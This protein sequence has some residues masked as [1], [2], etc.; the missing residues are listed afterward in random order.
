MQRRVA[1]T[2]LASVLM[3]TA[4]DRSIGQSIGRVGTTAAPFLK[5]GVGSRAMSMGEAYTTQAEDV[6]AMFW[7]PAGIASIAG[8]Q[9]LFS[10]YS[11]IADVAYSY[12]GV[13]IP[14]GGIGTFGAFVGYMD[15][16]TIE[17]T[18]IQSP[19][20]TGEQVSANS[21]V[22]GL[23][24]GR[25]LTDR[26]SLGGNVKYVRETIWHSTADA[27]A[28]DVGMLYKTFFKNIRIGMSISNF[29]SQMKMDGR[30]M[31][32]QHDLTT[33][34]PSNLNAHLD[35]DQFP[36]PILFRVGISSNIT[37]DLLGIQEH[38]WIVAVD[39][40]HPNDNKEY[41]NM[42]TEVRLYNRLISLRIGYRELLL[43]DRE[44]GLSFGVGFGINI[45]G[46]RVDVDYA[47]IGFGRFGNQN[48]F[49]VMMSF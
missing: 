9:A 22:V 48:M 26:F 37:G 8:L 7:N 28:F 20:G 36:L 30:D 45:E 46:G 27:F 11:Y 13:A 1:V 31:L 47:N 49:T 23:S 34:Y 10:Y 16:G 14:V 12:G 25:S 24:Y 19:E 6:S 42:G 44:G 17:R 5:I 41:L 29:G 40:V 39:A 4:V 3:V 35:T 18:T 32:V 38:D 21:I 33:A 43:A 15:Y 2:L